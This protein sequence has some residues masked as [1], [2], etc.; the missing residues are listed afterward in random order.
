[1]KRFW[2][3]VA[4]VDTADG[5]GIM[6]DARPVRTPERL[7][8]ILPTRA[9]ADAVAAEW[10]A[11]AEEVDPRSMAMTGLANAAIDRVRPDPAAF[12]TQ[13]A[14][15]AES[16]LLCY[17]ADGPATL[18]ARQAAVWDPLL[19]WARARYDIGFRVTAGIVHVAQPAE[20]P[21][22]LRAAVAAHDAF[23]LA[24]LSQLASIAGSVVI[25]L[26]AAEDAIAAD[27]AFDAAHL[28]ELWQ[29][30]R[31]GEDT[32][33]TEARRLRQAD[34][35]AAARFRALAAHG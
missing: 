8:L 24:A 34:F 13:I 20:T 16:D 7:P 15:Y 2:T 14:G 5:P 25:A 27:A 23:A 9:L 28:D 19:D 3:D 26:A 10:A 12:V 18:V 22:R 17:R 1:M 29:V 11:Q 31:W 21:P 4:V 35:V 33:A 30:E 6:L 32:L